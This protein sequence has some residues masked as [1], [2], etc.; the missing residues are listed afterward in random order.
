MIIATSGS[1]FIN[2]NII[3]SSSISP[4]TVSESKSFRDSSLSSSYLQLYGLY[5]IDQNNSVSL[6][7]DTKNKYT[8]LASINF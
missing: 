3:I 2:Y 7:Y 1:T 6:L 4:F 5:I 8:Y